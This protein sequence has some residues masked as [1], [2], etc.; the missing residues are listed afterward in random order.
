MHLHYKNWM[1][2][3]ATF[4][5]LQLC[6]PGGGHIQPRVNRES[7]YWLSSVNTV[8]ECITN[9]NGPQVVLE[10]V[11]VRIYSPG[12]EAE[13]LKRACLFSSPLLSVLVLFSISSAL[14]IDFLQPPLSVRL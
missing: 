4:T 3:A 13:Q 10:W 14:S 11:N 7:S 5:A 8:K 2:L 1:F 6:N 9:S 12:F